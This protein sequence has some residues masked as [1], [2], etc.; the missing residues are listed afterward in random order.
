[1]GGE[2]DKTQEKSITSSLHRIQTLQTK[3][4]RNVRKKEKEKYYYTY[5]SNNNSKINDKELKMMELIQDKN[6]KKEDYNLIHN[7]IEKHFFMQ[8]LKNN[9]KNEIIV[10]MSLYQVKPHSTIYSQ[11]SVGNY[12]FIVAE[13]QL[14]LL[15]DGVKKKTYSSGDNFGEIV[16]MNNNPHEG[17]VKTVTECV[18]WVLNKEVFEKIKNNPVENKDF[19]KSLNIP[20]KD[21]VKF[22]MANS[23][24]KNFYNA[25]DVICKEG[26]P[27]TSV[28]A[29]KE[30]EVNL[31][32]NGTFVKSI[33]RHEF[34]CEMALYDGYRSN[35]D[36]VAKT[37]SVIYS[38]PKEFFQEEFGNELK[39]QL[40]FTLLKIA[41]SQSTNFKS[42]NTNIL[43]KAFKSFNFKT[44]RKNGVIYRKDFDISKKM[45]VILDGNIIDKGT[46]R[47][48]G[49]SYDILF[50]D[51]VAKENEMKIK[52]DLISESNCVIA[53]AN[54]E[55]IQTA[56]GKSTIKNENISDSTEMKAIEKIRLFRNLNHS[57][58]ELIEKNLKVEKFN[59]GDK[60]LIQGNLGNKLYIIKKGKV[61]F[62]LDSK[63]IKSKHEGD[64]F[65]SKSLIV[66]DKKNLSSAV[67]NGPV[68]CYTLSADVF[69]N[70]LN[71]ELRQYFLNQYYLNDYTIELEDLDNIKTLGTGSYGVVSLVRSKKNKQLYA[72]KA[73]NL[74][75]IKEENILT[76]VEL[77][78]NLL[79]KMEH[80]FIAKTVKYVKG[81]IYLYYIME[82]VRGKELFDVLRDINLLNKQQTQ[83][84]S[85]SILEVIY[86][87]HSQ[88][89]MYRDLKPENIMV[90]ENGYIKFFDFGTV[91]EVK[92][93]RTKTFIGTISY[94]APEIFT[95]TGY[96]FQ[97]DMWSLGIMMY[98]FVCGKLPFGEEEEDP[99]QFYKILQRANLTFPPYV[100]DEVF[101]DLVKKLLIKDP[102]KRLSQYA[103]I[104]NHEYFKD[105]DFEKLMSLN[106]PA[107]YKFKLPDKISFSQPESY[108]AFLKS[109]GRKGYN[110]M[111]QSIRQIKFK[112]WLKDF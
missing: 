101:K 70:I 7:S 79:L 75:Q 13:G 83:F 12:W 3:S 33:K 26:D 10:N 93:G 56:L 97:V 59:N 54:N 80:P 21:E 91:K 64:D 42:I 99:V 66:N 103:L 43:N 46:N 109:L 1:M 49:K 81:E 110:K 111:K 95:G 31:L 87:L 19:L 73:M 107:P 85:A 89:V 51:N 74:M 61:D 5:N 94:M 2:F 96:S 18:L 50:E 48:V 67:A 106:L 108:L 6:A 62:F 90:L 76:R 44:F 41:F 112:K 69:K 102:N 27:I 9:E 37:N 28:Y 32:K 88:K 30:G 20:I 22:N 17:T 38:V 29:I 105:F 82:Y 68:E 63:Y 71:P 23:L 53:E 58:K 55:D 39:D 57:K 72:A 100:H 86:Y 60:I 52:N 36:I 92:S 16:L 104:R 15:I 35:F 65:G 45:C 34:F 77:E 78:K 25:R 24:V 47:V 98:E 14:E 11:G 84:Y 8:S 4:I 40:H